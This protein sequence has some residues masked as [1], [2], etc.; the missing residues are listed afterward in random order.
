VNLARATKAHLTEDGNAL[1]FADW[2]TEEGSAVHKTFKK[3]G[4]PLAVPL[5]PVMNLK[6]CVVP[7]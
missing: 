7:L 4:R 2:N 5:E 1:L 3:T 6:S